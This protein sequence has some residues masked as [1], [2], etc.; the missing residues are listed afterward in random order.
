MR[1]LKVHSRASSIS[2]E[3]SRFERELL[4]DRRPKRDSPIEE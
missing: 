3:E 2:V 4:D 1:G